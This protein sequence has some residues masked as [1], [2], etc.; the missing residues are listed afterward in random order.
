M[1][2]AIEYGNLGIIFE[3]KPKLLVEGNYQKEMAH[4]LALVGNKDKKT[5]VEIKRCDDRVEIAVSDEE[6]GFELCKYLELA[7]EAAITQWPRH[8]NGKYV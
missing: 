8:C 4:R 1:Q 7:P 5:I 3:K 6:Q 2:N